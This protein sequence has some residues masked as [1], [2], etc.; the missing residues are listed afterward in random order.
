MLQLKLEKNFILV[1]LKYFLEITEVILIF[2]QP[3][4]LGHGTK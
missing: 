3:T 1:Y 4:R 2:F